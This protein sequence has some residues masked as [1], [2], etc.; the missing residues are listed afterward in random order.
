MFGFKPEGGDTARTLVSV[1]HVGRRTGG[2]GTRTGCTGRTADA[3]H[4]G[5]VGHH[6]GVD[7]SSG[8]REAHG[9]RADHRRK[10]VDRV[11]SPR[12]T[13]RGQRST[14][15]TVPIIV[16]RVSWIEAAVERLHEAVELGSEPGL[17]RLDATLFLPPFGPS[18]LEPDLEER[19]KR[20]KW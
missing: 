12:K 17:Q 14:Q 10:T 8:R 15:L 18:V 19:G 4:A 6:V 13:L 5:Y 7:V 20:E 1:V 9:L 3:G 16:R 11:Q 2:I